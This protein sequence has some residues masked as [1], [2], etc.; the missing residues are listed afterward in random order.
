MSG[1][2]NNNERFEQIGQSWLKHAFTALQDNV[3][4]FGCTPAS[5]ALILASGCSDPYS[6][7]LNAGQ[8]GLGFTRVGES[9]HRRLPIDC[10]T[11]T[12]ATLIPAHRTGFWSK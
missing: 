6:A 5:T 10:Q 1:G 2:A 3:C 4:G 9:L 11:T 12:P 8:S 7:S